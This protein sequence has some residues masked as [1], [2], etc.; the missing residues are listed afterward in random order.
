[1]PIAPSV[2]AAA[3]TT[4]AAVSKT[5]I[6][7]SMSRSPRGTRS[8]VRVTSTATSAAA[9][10]VVRTATTAQGT[11]SSAAA[12][13]PTKNNAERGR[14]QDGEADSGG[15][16]ASAHAGRLAREHRDAR[17][18]QHDAEP[19]QSAR[20]VTV[21]DVEGQRDDRARGG[22]RR[23]DPHRPD[24][25]PPVERAEP[26]QARDAGAGGGEELD[27]PG[28]RVA[29]QA[30]PDRDS[31]ET[32]R[33]GDRE[34][35]EDRELACGEAAEEVAD[36]PE[37]GAGERQQRRHAGLVGVAPDGA[38]RGLRVELIRVVEDSGLGRPGCGPVVMA[39]D[40]VQQLRK[41]CRVEVP[42]PFLDHPEP[43]VDVAEQPSLLALA[44][45]RPA[46]QLAGAADVVQQRR[47]EQQVGAK[48][49]VE[50]RG[51]A[52]ERRDADRVLEQPAGVSVVAV[53]AGSGKL[54]EG[55][56]DGSVADEGAD[57]GRR[58]P[59]ARSPRRGTRRSRP[60]RPRRGGEW[61]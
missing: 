7:R 41:D 5:P 60:A 27:D 53:G 55:R 24:R 36:A 2:L 56:A 14:G 34:H 44:E 12:S 23:D 22:D 49:G 16:P 21:R 29:G 50:L 39:G 3:K 61:E 13:M 30:E 8:D 20:H 28:K 52:A 33:L 6:A 48:P 40:R 15:D 4:L 54:A 57:D 10:E 17:E 1:M 32:D 51:L 47:G 45:R 38:G 59:D 18:H 43:E 19:L 31:R 11:L 26:D 46:T 58:R 37:Q 42:R 9:T 35:R 25:H